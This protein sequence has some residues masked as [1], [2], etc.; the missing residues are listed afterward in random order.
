MV[1]RFWNYFR[2]G[3]RK[4]SSGLVKSRIFNPGGLAR[5]QQRHCTDQYRVLPS[6]NDHNLVWMTA[7]PSKITKVS[8]DCV[9]QICVATIR[10]MAQQGR[11]LF[12]ENL[13]PEPFPNV[14]GKFVNRGNAGD[15]RDIRSSIRCPRSNSFLVRSSGILLTRSEMRG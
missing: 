9:A 6:A 8:C 12:C 2:A 4:D 1:E 11:S 15:Q 7:S 13:C 10:C 5:I 14:D 3:K